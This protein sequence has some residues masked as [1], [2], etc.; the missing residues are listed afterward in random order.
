M[1]GCIDANNPPTRKRLHN[2]ANPYLIMSERL[3]AWL[4]QLTARV[5]AEICR[6]GLRSDFIQ[7]DGAVFM[8]EDRADSAFV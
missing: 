5:P 1:K 4:H 3:Q 2:D 6:Q 8:E 7:A